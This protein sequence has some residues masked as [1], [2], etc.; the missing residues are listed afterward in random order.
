MVCGHIGLVFSTRLI[1]EQKMYY[2]FMFQTKQTRESK[3]IRLRIH[4]F[5]PEILTIYL[6]YIEITFAENQ[7][8][9]R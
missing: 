4:K 6:V 5:K 2:P 1:F 3:N 8:A 9:K 7:K